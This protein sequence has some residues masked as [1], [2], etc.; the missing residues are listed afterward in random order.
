MIPRPTVP[1]PLPWSFPLPATTTYDN[2]LA[3][4]AYHLPGQYVLSCTLVLELPINAE[5]TGRDGVATIAARCL[6]EGTTAHP[7]PRFAAVLE[8][9]GA[10][11]DALVGLSTNQCLLDVPRDNLDRGL[12][13]LAEAVTSPAYD[14]D[15]VARIVANRLSEIEQQ[16]S[17]GSYLA[18]R[19][20]RQALIDPAQRLSRPTGGAAG[21]V[22]RISAADVQAFHQRHYRPGQATMILA[23]DLTGLDPAAAV[24]RAFAGWQVPGAHVTPEVARAA[25]PRRRLIH[26]AGAVQADIR[27]GWFGLDRRDPRWAAAQVGLA[28][29]GGTFTSRLNR[30]LREERGYTYGV[31]MMAHPHR[32]GGTIEVAASTKTASAAALV[33]EALDL[34]RADEPFTRQEVDDAATFLIRSAPLNFDTA[35]AVA[36]QAAS[37]AA[38]RLDLD[39]LAQTLRDLAEVT[40]ESAL[41]AYRSL[42]DAGQAS[43]IVVADAG[44]TGPLPGLDGADD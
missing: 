22:A 21:D 3:L 23:G 2:G 29:M 41:A 33:E 32:V 39:H 44:Q 9:A 37:L 14:P 6:D 40:P 11:F 4:W 43:V 7:G 16:E 12:A 36:A 19:A 35:E 17:R 28:V 10:Q 30:V 31:S 15:D 24:G 42:I 13:L 26:R 27:L 8:D 34:V 18:S 20:L 38:A 25:A 5:P 1:A